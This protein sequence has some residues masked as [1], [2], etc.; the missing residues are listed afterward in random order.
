VR[1]DSPHDQDFK[2]AEI[3]KGREIAYDGAPDGVAG[4]IVD[5]TFDDA[6]PAKMFDFSDPQHTAR[7]VT[8]TFDGLTVTVSVIQQGADYWATV[9]ADG[10]GTDAQK[11]AREIDA[12]AS[13]WAYKLP[14]YKGQQFL[15]TLES[16]LKPKGGPAPATQTPPPQH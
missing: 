2:L 9:S 4:S 11:E 8:K 3:P 12:H 13:G 15:S 7:I 5:F 16:L 14:A 10:R 1:R 6:K